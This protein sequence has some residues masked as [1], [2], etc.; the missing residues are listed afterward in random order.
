MLDFQIRQHTSIENT[1]FSGR[2]CRGSHSE[3]FSIANW[4][5]PLS[6]FECVNGRI[7]QSWPTL[8]DM[9]P[10]ASS[11]CWFRFISKFLLSY[12]YVIVDFSGQ[13]TC[14]V[15][16]QPISYSLFIRSWSGEMQGNSS[17]TEH[18]LTLRNVERFVLWLHLE[19]TYIV[20]LENSRHS[21]MQMKSHWNPEKNGRTVFNR[22][23]G[24]TSGGVCLRFG[25]RFLSSILLFFVPKFSVGVWVCLPSEWGRRAGRWA[26]QD[27]HPS[28]CAAVFCRR[29]GRRHYFSH[30]GIFFEYLLCIL[31]A[32]W[33]LDKP[34]SRTN[35]SNERKENSECV[36]VCVFAKAKEHTTTETW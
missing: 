8:S 19:E 27:K 13:S 2:I 29:P 12:L 32:A 28:F 35:G 4:K 10:L 21:G 31:C 5:C 34:N 3:M 24:R 30:L 23:R 18:F 17:E 7:F 25:I 1:I 36:C 16:Q 6:C 11:I 26:R 14:Q 20:L 33:H 22:T 15:I 9:A